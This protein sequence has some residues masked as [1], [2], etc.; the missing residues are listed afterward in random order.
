MKI[1]FL[2]CWY[3]NEHSNFHNFIREQKKDTDI[4]CFVEV[5]PDNFKEFKNVLDGFQG[6]YVTYNLFTISNCIY[7]QAIFVK[8]GLEV[9]REGKF[10]V[11]K[12]LKDDV[13]FVQHMTLK[14][15]DF[16]LNL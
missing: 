7:G 2:N 14:I 6:Y 3:A 1:I 12:N 10:R 9:I 8:K 13:G 15:D 11:Y 5:N 4:F 16:N